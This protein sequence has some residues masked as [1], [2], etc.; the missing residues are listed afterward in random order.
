[1]SQ[2]AFS[3]KKQQIR[4]AA[5]A[6]RKALADKN[7]ASQQITDRVMRM[8]E[9]EAARCVMWYVD[10]RDEVRTRHALPAAVASDKDIVI[11]YCVD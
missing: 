11:P 7:A 9:Y 3:E 4:K 1:M 6:A 8:A 2:D 10:I 5:H